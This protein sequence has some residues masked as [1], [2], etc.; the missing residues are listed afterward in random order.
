MSAPEEAFTVLLGRQATDEEKQALFRVRDALGLKNN[1]ALWSVLIAFEHYRTLYSRI[2]ELISKAASGTLATVKDAAETVMKA[3]AEA[4]KR[5]LAEAVARTAEQVARETARTR[6]LRWA[7]TCVAIAAASFALQ[8]V[9]AYR[10]GADAGYARGWSEGYRNARDE[11]AAA[12]W[13]NTPEGQLAYGLAK[14]GS[15]R[16]L[17]TCGGQGWVQKKRVCLPMP[18]RGTVHGW[19]LALDEKPGR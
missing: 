7:A 14:A 11:R 19:V 12:S 15:I 3:A 18:D 6:M 9:L 2:P 5:D 16:A 4:T 8:G 1:D 17:A 13:A 10:H